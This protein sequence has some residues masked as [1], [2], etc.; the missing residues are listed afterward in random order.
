[1][2]AQSKVSIAKQLSLGAFLVATFIE[3]KTRREFLLQN[4][5]HIAENCFTILI[6]SLV[7]LRNPDIVQR[8]KC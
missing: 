5:A 7:E 1:M 6:L 3:H 2:A 4:V 8:G